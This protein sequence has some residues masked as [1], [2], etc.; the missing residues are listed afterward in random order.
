MAKKYMPWEE[1]GLV[2]LLGGLSVLGLAV[3]GLWIYRWAWDP[4]ALVTMTANEEYLY[5]AIA[6]GIG[7]VVLA[8]VLAMT[9]AKKSG[10]RIVGVGRKKRPEGQRFEDRRRRR[11]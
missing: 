9:T 2:S 7:F 3:A 5:G 8:I 1:I 10:S 4:E 6:F 11:G